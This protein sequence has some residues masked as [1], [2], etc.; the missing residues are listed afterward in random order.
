MKILIVVVN[1]LPDENA[2]DGAEN[3]LE[4]AGSPGREF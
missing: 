3:Y 2:P 1:W 4:K